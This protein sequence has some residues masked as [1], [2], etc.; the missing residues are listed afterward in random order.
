MGLFR[1][2]GK[3]VKGGDDVLDMELSSFSSW[4]GG[5]MVNPDGKVVGIVTTPD[6]KASKAVAASAIKRFLGD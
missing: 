6:L 3:V 5:P 4:I 1:F 2:D